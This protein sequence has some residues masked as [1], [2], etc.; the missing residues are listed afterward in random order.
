MSY[1]NW[2]MSDKRK[3]QRNRQ[4]KRKKKKD[5]VDPGG[6]TPPVYDF[7]HPDSFEMK[8]VEDLI[9]SCLETCPHSKV[10]DT[11][12]KK[13]KWA[14]EIDRMKRLD[15]LSEDEIWQVLQYAM[16][17]GFWKGNIRST[18]KLREKFETLYTQSQGKHG[19]GYETVG[20]PGIAEEKFGRKVQ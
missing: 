10:P 1:W 20:S 9:A 13:K 7:S 3:R 11:L 18:K 8:C 12:E 6:P 14:A 17:D 5:I 4:R 16:H 2:T 15:G 19:I